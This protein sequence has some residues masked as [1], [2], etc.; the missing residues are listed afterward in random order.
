MLIVDMQR[1]T[2]NTSPFAEKFIDRA[3]TPIKLL[4]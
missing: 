3:E 2:N 1:K 4:H